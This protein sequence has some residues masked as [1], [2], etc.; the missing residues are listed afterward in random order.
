VVNSQLLAR[1]VS[2]AELETATET[3][4]SALRNAIT[5]P[6]GR[7]ILGPHPEAKCEYRIRTRETS[8]VID[9]LIRDA[10]GIQWAVDYK[11]SSHQGTDVE[12]F[13]DRERERYGAQLDAY[14][15]VLG[16]ARRALYFP[17]LL[18]WREW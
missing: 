9:R 16:G 17:L 14:S 13:L 15:A 1:G 5:D 2:G 8:Y 3:V 12:G 4:L 18:G 10:Q 11:T 7:W 6:R